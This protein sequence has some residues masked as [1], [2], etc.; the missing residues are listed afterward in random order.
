MGISFAGV[1]RIEGMSDEDGVESLFFFFFLGGFY[2]YLPAGVLRIVFRVLPHLL[3]VGGSILQFPGDE[4]FSLPR[5]PK[6][7]TRIRVQCV[8]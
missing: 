2:I 3:P 1:F 6:P 5:D 7:D 4:G 8:P